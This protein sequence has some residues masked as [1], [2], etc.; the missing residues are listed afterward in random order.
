MPQRPANRSANN[1]AG[2]GLKHHHPPDPQNS[3]TY[4][5]LANGDRDL[6]SAF[7]SLPAPSV[8]IRADGNPMLNRLDGERLALA[9][10]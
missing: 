7:M 9:V 6:P 8:A 1:C 10:C 2:A 3:R 5:T 4:W